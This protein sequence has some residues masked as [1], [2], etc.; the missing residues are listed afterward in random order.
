MLSDGLVRCIDDQRVK[1]DA[2]EKLQSGNLDAKGI[3][4]YT[5]ILTEDKQKAEEAEA[6]YVLADLMRKNQF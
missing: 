3:Y 6:R 2:E 1:L 5:L 4:H